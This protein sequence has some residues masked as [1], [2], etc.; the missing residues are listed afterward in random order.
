[1]SQQI[2]ILG[3]Y[4][5][6]PIGLYL[7][8]KEVFLPLSSFVEFRKIFRK[9]AENGSAYQRPGQPSLYFYRSEYM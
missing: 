3:G 9:E 5:S 7:V 1:M 2:R 6:F 8:E 4:L